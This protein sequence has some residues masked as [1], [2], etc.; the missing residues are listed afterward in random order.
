MALAMARYLHKQLIDEQRAHLICREQYD[1]LKAIY[2]KSFHDL[3]RAD[4][5]KRDLE[6]VKRQ[7][8][9]SN[10]D[11]VVRNSD[12][13][14][15]CGS[16]QQSLDLLRK[17]KL[18]WQREKEDLLNELNKFGALKEDH[19]KLQE[20][21][22]SVKAEK[23]KETEDSF[24]ALLAE[25]TRYF[26]QATSRFAMISELDEKLAAA[27]ASFEELKRNYEDEKKTSIETAIRDFRQ[28]KECYSLKAKYGIGFLK[29]GFY[30]ARQYLEEVRG[31]SFP[32][33]V[34]T[35]LIEDSCFVD[36]VD[37]GYAPNDEDVDA[38]L[39]T[40]LYDD[41]E[42]LSGPW[43]FYGEHGVCAQQSTK[44]V[45]VESV[46]N[47]PASDDRIGAL[48]DLDE[49]DEMTEDPPGDS[50]IPSTSTAPGDSLIPLTS[51]STIPSTVPN[52]SEGVLGCP[53]ADT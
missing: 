10:R 34:Y 28:S 45:P 41:L 32:E 11:L 7:L 49:D 5:A 31:E 35:P 17:E 26:E 22:E 14:S 40:Y 51:A 50:S 38:H 44:P 52:V 43:E 1:K 46:P 33:L 39:D 36:W 21:L 48:D 53:P 19:V 23:H 27:N 3:T 20:K 25:K 8:E 13:I 29:L 24:S 42:N 2:G 37:L 47:P 18:E 12:L 6:R 30:K 4:N 9:D 16:L 15:E